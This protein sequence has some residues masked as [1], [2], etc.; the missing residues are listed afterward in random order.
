[1]NQARVEASCSACG[2][3]MLVE[4]A[5]LQTIVACPR[6][7]TTVTVAELVPATT[8]LA[9]IPVAP[10]PNTGHSLSEVDAPT[11]LEAPWHQVGGPTS[12]PEPA[13]ASRGGPEVSEPESTAALSATGGP[14][15]PSLET[16]ATPPPGDRLVAPRAVDLAT[17]ST[18]NVAERTRQAYGAMSRTMSALGKAAA[19]FDVKLY[20]YR[21]LVLVGLAGMVVLL[22]LVHLA[23]YAVALP[24]FALVAYFMLLARLWSLRGE[25]G[26]WSVNAFVERAGAFAENLIESLREL[27]VTPLNEHLRRLRGQAIGLGLVLLAVVPPVRLLVLRSLEAFGLSTNDSSAMETLA[28][29]EVVGFALVGAGALIAFFRWHRMRGSKFG[30]HLSRLRRTFTQTDGVPAVFDVWKLPEGTSGVVADPEFQRLLQVLRTWR[31]REHR[32]EAAYEASLMRHLRKYFTRV[33]IDNQVPL[34]TPDGQRAGRVDIVLDNT[35]AVELKRA[36]TST[37]ADRALG[38]VWKYLEGWSRGPVVLLL[39]VTKDGF[40][41]G[42]LPKHISALRQHGHYVFAVAAGRRI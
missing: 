3:L 18:V 6:C 39:C 42:M 37:E 19:W 22:R 16:D 23:A 33:E 10:A 5:D 35:V 4:T 30:N 40:E 21:S 31:P 11:I 8:P 7:R 26:T 2:Q 13:Q 41:L 38:Q 17:G 9:A 28:T 36:L 29:T 20:G 34:R 27:P 15:S 1:M 12:I 14:E 32:L 24:L 25:D